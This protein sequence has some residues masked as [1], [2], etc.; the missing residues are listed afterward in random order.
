MKILIVDDDGYQVSYIKEI[1]EIEGNECIATRNVDDAFDAF[2]RLKTSIDFVILD[3]MMKNGE[4]IAPEVGLENGEV[5][6]KYM[7]NVLPDLPVVI[8]TAKSFDEINIKTDNKTAILIKPIMDTD[9]IL[10]AYEE[11]K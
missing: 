8:I 3:L 11:I 7:K 5:L 2:N 1:L 6:Y 4:K 10:E 9:K